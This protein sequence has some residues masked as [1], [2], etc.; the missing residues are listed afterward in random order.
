MILVVGIT[1]FFYGLMVARI[2]GDA[3]AIGGQVDARLV[4]QVVWNDG[5]DLKP[6]SGAV[7]VAIP[8]TIQ[9]DQRYSSRTLHPDRFVPLDNPVIDAIRA[10]GGDVTRASDDG[11]FELYV[12]GPERFQI[13]FVSA[14]QDRRDGGLSRIQAAE[15]G[16]VFQDPEEL[17]AGREFAVQ[18]LQLNTRFHD[19]GTVRF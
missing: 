13:L 2:G 16:V 10:A 9:P 11:K 1:G 17:V 6:D 12:A 15:L 3:P 7:V 14:H 5:G 18:E 8:V 19:I 4:G